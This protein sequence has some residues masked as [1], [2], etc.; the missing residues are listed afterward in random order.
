MHYVVAG[1]LSTGHC[2]VAFRKR[3]L[4][5]MASACN[6]SLVI[7][8]V[9]RDDAGRAEMVLRGVTGRERHGEKARLI[10]EKS[11][12]RTR[13]RVDVSYGEKQSVG[14][15]TIFLIIFLILDE[16]GDATDAGGNCGDTTGHCFEGGEAEGLHLAGHEHQ[17]GEREEFVDIVLLAEEMNLVA[18][19]ETVSEVFGG[20]A[21]GAV[22]DEHETGGKR[23]GDAAEDFD[24][25]GD[26]LNRAEVRE[27]DEETLTGFGIAGT[28]GGDLLRVALVEVAIDEVADDFNL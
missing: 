8:F 16:F 12:S 23:V 24:D 1:S 25:I 18:D 20:R 17:V 4:C 9:E 5:V 21:V 7:L 10:A 27:M 26:A 28:H 14:A 3:E 11:D 13:H 19:T 15:L 6:Y 2:K 22:T